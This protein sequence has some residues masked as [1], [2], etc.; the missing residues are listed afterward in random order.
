MYIL[1]DITEKTKTKPDFNRK[2]S[3]YINFSSK[4]F[5]C[6]KK[7]YNNK[8]MTKKKFLDNILHLKKSYRVVC[9]LSTLTFLL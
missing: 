8:E 9:E 6:H 4:K 2:S 7:Y 3:R 1:Y 5:F